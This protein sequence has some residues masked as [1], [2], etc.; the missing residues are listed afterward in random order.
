MISSITNRPSGLVTSAP[1]RG[2]AI[3]PKGAKVRWIGTRWAHA[4]PRTNDNIGSLSLCGREELVLG[5]RVSVDSRD[6]KCPQC[7]WLRNER[8]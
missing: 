5:L 8:E 7:D 4:Y 3:L 2:V 6:P 1:R